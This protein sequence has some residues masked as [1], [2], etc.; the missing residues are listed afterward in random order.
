M[1]HI[2]DLTVPEKATIISDL[3]EGKTTLEISRIVS[4]Y[5]GKVE[6]F[7]A[8]PD[9]VLTIADRGSLRTVSIRT[10]SR[11]KREVSLNPCFTSNEN[12]RHVDENTVSKVQAFAFLKRSLDDSSLLKS[13]MYRKFIS[14]ERIAFILCMQ[15]GACCF[16][17]HPTAL[18]R[19]KKLILRK[20]IQVHFIFLAPTRMGS[21]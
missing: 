21:H 2:G 1:G 5:H 13:L 17:K 15:L 6:K 9:A 14:T 10:L 8:T 11:L 18:M 20:C 7:M 12:F 16:F 3:V 19:L 4:R